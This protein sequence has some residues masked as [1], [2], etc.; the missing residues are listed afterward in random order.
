M[1]LIK[2]ALDLA[3]EIC[4][5]TIGQVGLFLLGMVLCYFLYRRKIRGYDKAKQEFKDIQLLQ[6]GHWIGVRERAGGP[7]YFSVDGILPKVERLAQALDEQIPTA[8][9]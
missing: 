4:A 7:L 1:G 8:V 5:M 3:K 6:N 9:V 2:D